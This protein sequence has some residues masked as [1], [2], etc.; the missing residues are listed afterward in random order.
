MRVLHRMEF[1]YSLSA[2][3]AIMAGG[4]KEREEGQTVAEYSMI[5]GVIVVG[6]IAA[7]STLRTAVVAGLTA[8]ASAI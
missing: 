2:R 3:L 8:A 5:V 4:L 1:V 7:V 6:L